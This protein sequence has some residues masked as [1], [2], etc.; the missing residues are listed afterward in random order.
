MRTQRLLGIGL[1]A[2][3][4]LG[5]WLTLQITYRSFDND[6]GPQLFPMI[7]F[8]IL[9]LSGLGGLMTS[10]GDEPI[11]D[12]SAT[13]GTLRRGVT[14]LAMMIAYAIGLWLVGYLIAT[15]LALYGFYHLIAKP[16]V[17]R[18]RR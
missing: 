6:P 13:P 18:G 1:I 5:I 9:I 11:N 7:G 3:G 17:G 8:A 14:A 2:F 16:P 4:G 10:T 12:A 15:F